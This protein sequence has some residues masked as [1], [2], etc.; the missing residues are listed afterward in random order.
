MRHPFHWDTMET[1]KSQLLSYCPGSASIFHSHF[2]DFSWDL[3]SVHWVR[4]AIQKVYKERRLVEAYEQFVGNK[5]KGW[6]SKR[7]LHKNKTWNFLK[8]NY[9]LPPDMHIYVCI[10]QGVRN[11]H[12]SGNLVCFVFL[13]HP[14]W[15][16]PFFLINEK[17]VEPRKIKMDVLTSKI[18]EINLKNANAK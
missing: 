1:Y 7:V 4:K 5:E 9:F 8:N 2:L 12:F 3:H 13:K 17:L 14:F 15:D 18:K 6:I 16:S 10:P 11:V